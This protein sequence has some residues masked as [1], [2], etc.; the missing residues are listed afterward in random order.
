MRKREM[1]DEDE[2][3][4]EDMSKYEKSGM[5]CLIGLGRPRVGVI[6]HQIRTRDCHI[7]D[8]LITR[9]NNSGMSYFDM[10]ISPISSHL[11]PSCPQLSHHPRTQS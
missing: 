2:N 10:M 4:V 3:D 5:T 7:K 6:T 1:E 9:T 11:S 8:G